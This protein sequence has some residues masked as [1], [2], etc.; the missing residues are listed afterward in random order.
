M[1]VKETI[2]AR[3]AAS[4]AGRQVVSYAQCSCSRCACE[5]RVKKLLPCLHPFPRVHDSSFFDIP[6]SATDVSVP[7]EET[8][9][10]ANR[11]LVADEDVQD[12]VRALLTL[13]AD[14]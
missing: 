4:T 12:A 3:T 13:Q 8:I 5:N 1:R 2:M 14:V 6:S 9:S 7:I 11:K 10:A